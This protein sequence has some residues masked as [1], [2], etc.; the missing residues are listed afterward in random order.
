VLVCGNYLPLAMIPASSPHYHMAD[1]GLVAHVWPDQCTDV[2]EDA[3]FLSA[4]EGMHFG[5]WLVDFLPRLRGWKRPMKIAIPDTL[6]AKHRDTLACFGVEK[7][8]LVE[9]SFG[10]RYRFR[11]LTVVVTGDHQSPQPA[12][13]RFVY[14]GLSDPRPLGTGTRRLFVNR[15]IGTRQI[16]NRDAFDPVLKSHCITEVDLAKI[17]IADQRTLLGETE[18]V[19]G[20]YGS[21]L[22]CMFMLPAGAEVVE[23]VSETIDHP[24]FARYAAILG[25]RHHLIQARSAKKTGR[26]VYKKDHDLDV[27]CEELSR[28]LDEIAARRAKSRKRGT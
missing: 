12:N 18:L 1:L 24:V 28:R 21:D 5:H 27:D 9:C 22:Y 4:P 26:R 3:L 7:G 13:P 20:V 8:D 10:G 17:S 16:A 14:Q 19:I 25:M 2:D 6:P 23:L 11:S 15:G